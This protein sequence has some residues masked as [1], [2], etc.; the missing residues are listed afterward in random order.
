MI[1]V[2][3]QCH[4]LALCFKHLVNKFPW[5]SEIEKLLLRLWKTFHHSSLNCH[6]FSKLQQAYDLQPHHLVKAAVT[7]WLSHG[8]AC[9][10]EREQYEQ[11]F[12]A[13]DEIISKNPNSE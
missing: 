13:L 7:S 1:Y 12:L 3:C 8:Q 11:I 2:N 6:I 10:R 5:L 4:R 9:K